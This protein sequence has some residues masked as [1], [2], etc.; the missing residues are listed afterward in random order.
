MQK[1][2]LLPLI[3]HY[4]ATISLRESMLQRDHRVC[5]WPCIHLHNSEEQCLA[6]RLF[7]VRELLMSDER[8]RRGFAEHSATEETVTG[9]ADPAGTAFSQY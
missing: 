3:G 4:S 6:Y 5:C 8:L 9:Y 2:V 1:C 7:A